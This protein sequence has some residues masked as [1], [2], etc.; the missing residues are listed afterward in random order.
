MVDHDMFGNIADFLLPKC[1]RR[2]I[3]LGSLLVLG[4]RG[5]EES[6]LGAIL[7]KMLKG[8]VIDFTPWGRKFGLFL[9][10]GEGVGVGF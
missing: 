10:N 7:L 4:K 3:F 2:W 8:V 9:G 6:I 1:G 5:D